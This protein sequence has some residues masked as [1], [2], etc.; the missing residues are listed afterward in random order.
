MYKFFRPIGY[1]AVLGAVSLSPAIAQSRDS[2]SASADSAPQTQGRLD[3]NHD[4]KVNILDVQLTMKQV[5]AGERSML[6]VLRE[7]YL[8][9]LGNPPDAEARWVVFY[10]SKFPRDPDANGDGR[11]DVLDLQTRVNQILAGDRSKLPLYRQTIYKIFETVPGKNLEFDARVDR[12][13]KSLE[14]QL[15]RSRQKR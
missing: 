11:Y 5:L 12:D 8:H 10:G 9:M 4:G 15:E 14:Q 13:C 2:A 7:T 3:P 6:P 1:A